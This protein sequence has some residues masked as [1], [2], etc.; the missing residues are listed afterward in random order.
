[1]I[2]P[3]LSWVLR[4]TAESTGASL[5]IMLSLAHGNL[6]PVCL[7]AGSVTMTTTTPTVTALL[8]TAVGQL[9][10]LPWKQDTRLLCTGREF[11]LV[12]GT[13]LVA[14]NNTGIYYASNSTHTS[15][16]KSIFLCTGRSGY[17]PS[18]K[19]Q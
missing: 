7:P 12:T 3:K 9:A 1:M 14:S 13:L 10:R 2:L 15:W 8:Y 5:A 4:I 11:N 17:A 19:K 16:R 6:R 18:F